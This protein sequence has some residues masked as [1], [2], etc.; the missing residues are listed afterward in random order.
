[1]TSAAEIKRYKARN[2]RYKKPIAKDL[3]LDGIKEALWDISDAC[4]DVQYY[5][6]GDEETLLN[7]LDG[8]EDDAYEFKMMFSDLVAECEQMQEDLGNEY[9]PEY[10]DI[11]FA[12][13]DKGGD[14]LGYDA[15][16]RDYYGLSRYE[17]EWANKEAVKK[18]KSLT[19][20]QLIE[21]MQIC[22][23]VYQAYIGL[24]HRY[25]CIKAAMDILRDENTGFLQMVKQI[26]EFYE[27]ANEE[28][29]GFK[30][31]Y[32]GWTALKKFDR[33]LDNMPQE[34]WIQ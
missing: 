23:G 21:A 18:I 9:I 20:D 34:A 17:S 31:T 5:V 33:M 24:Q 7:A 25:D 8:D 26:E 27:K 30:W 29:E 15:Y 11:F 2:L 28:T 32:G 3:N 12:A 13:I 10:F 6:D 4:Y 16:E 22:F 19:K 1:M 14:M